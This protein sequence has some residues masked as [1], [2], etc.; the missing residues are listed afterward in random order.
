V[1]LFHPKCLYADPPPPINCDCLQ[2][3]V[4]DR[5][6]FIAQLVKEKTTFRFAKCKIILFEKGTPAFIVCAR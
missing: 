5:G 4:T 6:R 3:V 2:E 1:S